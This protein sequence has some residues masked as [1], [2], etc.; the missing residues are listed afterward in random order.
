MNCHGQQDSQTNG[1]NHAKHGSWLM[2][3]CCAIPLAL[4]GAAL[5]FGYRGALTGLLVLLCPL[6]HVGLMVWLARGAKRKERMPSAGQA[7][8]RQLG[9]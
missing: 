2:L 4:I 3:L 6:M 7:E 8:P 5:L 1:T 9:D